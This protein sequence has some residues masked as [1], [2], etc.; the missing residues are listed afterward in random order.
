MPIMVRLKAGLERVAGD[1]ASATGPASVPKWSRVFDAVGVAKTP[2]GL[3]VGALD[4]TF[5]VGEVVVEEGRVG[6]LG[7]PHSAQKLAPSANGWPQ[8]THRRSLMGAI[9]RHR[10]AV[11]HAS[12][13]PRV[14]SYTR[15]PFPCRVSLRLGQPAFGSASRQ[16]HGKKA[17]CAC[18]SW[19]VGRA[20]TASSSRR[21][22]NGCL[23]T[24]DLDPPAR[25]SACG[26]SEPT[27]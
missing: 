13:R 18:S 10:H 14:A 3:G 27:W 24:L 17:R 15:A 4:G 26:R 5:A 23:S 6:P 12:V 11:R 8:C 22:A 20:A 9:L 16:G 7:A 2:A 1:S 21:K 25:S 19:G